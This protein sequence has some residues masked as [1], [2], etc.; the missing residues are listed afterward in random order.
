MEHTSRIELAR[1]RLRIARRAIGVVA[2]AGFVAFVFAA[3]ASHPGSGTR[4]RAS[5]SGSGGASAA[6]S[7]QDDSGFS[8]GQGSIAP[9]TGGGSALQ[10]GGS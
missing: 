7:E 9:S 8:F 2:A 5:T 4:P 6:T 10:S 3:R 1:H